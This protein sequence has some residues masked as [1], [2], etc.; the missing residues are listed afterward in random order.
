MKQRWINELA[1]YDFSQEYQK[2]KN[3]TVA[4][5][6]SRIKEEQLSDEEADKFLKFV[7]MI[8][9]DETVVKIFKEEVCDQKPESPAPY[10][11]SL[12]AMKAIFH[13]LTSGAGRR[14]ELEYNVDSPIHNEADSIKVSVKSA[15]L[16]SQMHVTN[17]AEAQQEDPEIKA[18]MDWCWLNRKKS[19]PW[20]QQLL[21]FKSHLGP[22]KNTRTGKSLLR[23]AD[24]LTLCGGLLYH[25]YMPKYQV[26]E[27]K[28]FV[29]QR[30]HRRTAINGCHRDAEHQGKKRMESLVSD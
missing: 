24:R 5:A 1:K 2:G 3:N 8:P 27:V 9:G 17:W 21:K 25:R 6:L 18:A 4:D 28:C 11:M 13:N 19:E 14:A 16:N 20:T 23:N 26:D 22:N 7:P 15:R 30:A 29:V 12:A 10:T